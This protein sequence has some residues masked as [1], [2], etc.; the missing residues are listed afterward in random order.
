MLVSARSFTVVDR[1]WTCARQ[2]WWLERRV[3]NAPMSGD[4]IAVEG[5]FC[6][7][8]RERPSSRIRPRIRLRHGQRPRAWP[9]TQNQL[10][11][12]GLNACEI[13][14]VSRM[15]F[16]WRLQAVGHKRLNDYVRKENHATHDTETWLYGVGMGGMR[17][18]WLP[19]AGMFRSSR[20]PIRHARA[21]ST[22]YSR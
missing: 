9:P 12:H 6:V 20:G 2:E 14:G 7:I 18:T 5:R 10:I 3:Y 17:R 4:R 22:N 21:G 19:D 13:A 16:S 15:D 11:P 1:T 8:G